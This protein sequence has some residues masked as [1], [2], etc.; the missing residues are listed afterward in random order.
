LLIKKSYKIS[1]RDLIEVCLKQGDL[2]S[3]YVS[4]TRALEGIREHTRVQSLRPEHYK[5]EVSVSIFVNHTEFVLEVM[6]RIDGIFE[7]EEPI[8]IEEIKTSRQPVQHMAD[9]PLPLH[10]AQLKCYGHMIAEQRRLDAVFLQLTYVKVRSQAMAENKAKYTAAEL[11]DF[12]ESLT[13]KYLQI[14]SDQINWE[15]VRNDSIK[16]MVFPY[17]HFRQSQRQLAEGVY[18]I[19]KNE[20]ILFARAPTGTGKTIAVLFPAIKSL[21]LGH[22]DKIFYLT[23]KTIGRTVAL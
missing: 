8:T 1:V 21:G 18:K 10:M 5:K 3:S 12:F 17:E 6:G 16:Q 19:I 4:R 11:K 15:Q 23:A 20:K 2:G 14:L 7:S 13:G 22:I 9:N